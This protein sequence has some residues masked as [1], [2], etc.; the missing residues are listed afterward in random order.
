MSDSLLEQVAAEIL[1]LRDTI[2]GRAIRE[3]SLRVDAGTTR[4]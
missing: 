2:I 4:H 3:A 1:A